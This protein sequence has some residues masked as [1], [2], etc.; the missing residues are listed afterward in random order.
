MDLSVIIVNYRGWKSLKEC[1]DELA[2]FRGTSFRC[3]VIIVDNNSEDGR[4]DDFREQYPHFSF[5]INKVNGGFANGCNLGSKNAKGEF[6]LFL[7]PDTVASENEVGRLLNRARENRSD[8]ISS[9]RQVNES[10]RESKAFGIFPQFGTLTGFGRAVYRI[11]RRK[12]ITR[13]TEEKNNVI[14]PDWISGSVVMINNE[15]FRKLGGFDEDF[16]MYYEDTDL[17]KRARDKK[18]EI[19]F[20]TDITIQHNHGGSSRVNLD[21]SSLTKTEVLIS[22]HIYISK[23]SAGAGRILLQTYLVVNNIMSGLMMAIIGL[24]FFLSEPRIFVRVYIYG[25]LIG[26]Y[27]KAVMR[28]SWIS[29]RSVHF[30]KNE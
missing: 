12:I 4:I 27:A 22:R 2:A 19:A 5:I 15:I 7:N 1:L 10:G 6:F 9:C 26:Y 11:V 30:I 13:K 18:G 29:P 24:M 23:H 28:G 3:E 14:R 17:C 25:K 8:H 21:T 16:W 20:Y